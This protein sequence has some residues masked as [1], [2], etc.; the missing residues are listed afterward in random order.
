VNQAAGSDLHGTEQPQHSFALDS[1]DRPRF[2]WSNGWGNGHLTGIY[3]AHCDDTDCTQ[4]GSWK[5]ALVENLDTKTV[6]ADNA[7]L[8]FDGD[9]PRVLTRM[10]YSGLPVGVEYMECN[11]DCDYQ[12]DWQMSDVSHPEG[13]MWASWDLALD[14]NGHPRVALYEAADPALTVGGKLYYGW[15]DTNCT[16]QDNPF[17]LVQVASGEGKN[18]DLAIDTH[19]RIT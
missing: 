1:Q 7:T 8:V 10:N 15:C 3:Y 18:V 13:K 4:T 17:Q 12:Y 6:T 9:K 19:G 11:M 16:S 14:A 5:Q 2:I